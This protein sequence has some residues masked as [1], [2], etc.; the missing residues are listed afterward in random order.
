FEEMVTTTNDSSPAGGSS[1]TTTTTTTTTS[2]TPLTTLS[3]R[4]AHTRRKSTDET[5]TTTTTSS[6]SSLQQYVSDLAE[7]AGNAQRELKQVHQSISETLQSQPQPGRKLTATFNEIPRFWQDNI[8]I[9]SGYRWPT[10]S[11]RGCVNSLFYIHN[12]T[13]NVYSHL[14]GGIMF[15]GLWGVT[16]W[17]LVG[18][19]AASMTASAKATMGATMD[20]WMNGISAAWNKIDYVGIVVLITGSFVPAAYYGFFCDPHLQLFYLTSISIFGAA[21]IA[22]TVSPRFAKPEFRGL[23]TGLFT[24]MGLS[25]V[26]PLVH[27]VALYGVEYARYAMS[28]EY[29]VLM[30]FFYLLGAAIYISRVPERWFPGKFDI[31]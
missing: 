1:S 8:Y 19:H 28:F 25:G 2:S 11:Y 15:L 7:Y 10:Y 27:S 14:V 18:N 23:R 20:A 29:L 22:I 3:H 5:T 4:V 9:R 31:W 12:E 21:T 30:A 16:Y 26:L 13:A 6:S 17:T 24:S